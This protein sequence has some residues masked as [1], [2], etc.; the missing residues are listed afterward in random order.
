M[1]ALSN[2]LSRITLPDMSP[3]QEPTHQTRRDADVEI[4]R[5][6]FQLRIYVTPEQIVPLE[7][8]SPARASLE[9]F[10]FDEGFEAAR[11][12]GNF[13]RSRI[14]PEQYRED[15]AVHRYW[16][17]F[18]RKTHPDY[19]RTG[20]ASSLLVAFEIV[21]RELDL[22]DTHLHFEWM[23][24]DTK[25]GAV[26][27]LA[28][29]HGYVPH[30]LDQPYLETLLAEETTDIGQVPRERPTLRFWKL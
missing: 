24:I 26:A 22:R 21:V 29:R 20:L 13:C 1:F 2:A 6:R 18:N 15:G 14:S 3:R 9:L 17:V 19:R 30:P 4:G 10:L 23:Q 8:A 12:R 7:L 25:V 5:R 16:D 27:H 28:L 11:I